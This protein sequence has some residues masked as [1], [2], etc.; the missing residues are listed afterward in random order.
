MTSKIHQSACN[1]KK[2]S[3][4]GSIPLYYDRRTDRDDG[5]KSFRLNTLCCWQSR[6]C[7]N[8]EHSR[9]KR[10][11]IGCWKAQLKGPHCVAAK[12]KHTAIVFYTSSV[13]SVEGRS[14]VASVGRSVF[15]STSPL[16]S[17][18]GHST[19]HRKNVADSTK[20]C[21]QIPVLY[22]LPLPSFLLQESINLIP[23][24]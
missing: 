9:H 7:I 21:H 13:K 17:F 4:Y 23:H 12:T 6:A 16:L 15:E 24:H 3:C 14:P 2:Y 20:D 22:I 11:I 8:V 5:K 19:R 1:T 18:T 10:L